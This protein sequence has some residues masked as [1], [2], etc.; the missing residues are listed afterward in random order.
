[1]LSP[2]SVFKH[3]VFLSLYFI[4][5]FANA[6]THSSAATD[7]VGGAGRAAVDAGDVNYLNPA[8]LV[9]VKGRYIYST[10]SRDDLSLGLSETSKDVVVPGNFS[11]FEKKNTD[12]PNMDIRTQEFRLSLADFVF[13]RFAMGLTG[14][15][16]TTKLNGASY[17]QTNGNFGFFYTPTDTIGTALVLY[18]VFDAPSNV[19]LILRLQKEMALGFNAIYKNFLRV[20]FDVLSA[21]ENNFGKSAYMAGFETVLNE[22]LVA[23]VGYKNDIN[24]NQELITEGFGFNGPLFVLNYAHQGNMKGAEFDRHSIDLLFSF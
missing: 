15:M 9:H 1:M 5:S 18:N 16:D 4:V 17:A 13:K 14:I 24:A 10:V 12:D 22:F 2:L 11:F 8:A 7:A 21:P 20:R 6:Q 3:P 19:P 23:R